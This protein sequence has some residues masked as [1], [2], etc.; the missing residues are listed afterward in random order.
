MRIPAGGLLGVPLVS[1][2][3]PPNP[4][5]VPQAKSAAS[6]PVTAAAR[7][8]AGLDLSRL[9][10]IPPLVEQA[11]ADRKLPGAVVLVGRGDRVVWQRASRRRAPRPARGPA[12]ADPHF[13]RPR[14]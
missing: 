5:P 13:D 9:D 8:E 6:K 3:G 12:R 7:A 11:I 2:L 4:A 14:A 10:A 1:Q